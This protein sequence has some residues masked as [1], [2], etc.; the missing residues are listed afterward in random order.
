MGTGTGAGAGAAMT[1]DTVALPSGLSAES[2][3]EGEGKGR[4][5]YDH[6]V[7]SVARMIFHVCQS[8]MLPRIL[9]PTRSSRGHSSL[10][11]LAIV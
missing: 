10:L 7:S 8:V 11:V 5:S 3:P 2:R 4:T 6:L 9:W 1:S